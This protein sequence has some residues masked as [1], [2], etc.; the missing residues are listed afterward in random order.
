MKNDRSQKRSLRKALLV[1]GEFLLLAVTGVIAAIL[2][3]K[4]A[5]Q[6]ALLE[7]KRYQDSRAQE[8]QNKIQTFL[9]SATQL[10]ETLRILLENY[11]GNERVRIEEYLHRI[12]ESAPASLVYGA[13]A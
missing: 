3:E 6:T 7:V 1:F 4:S 5:H 9:L 2:V 8:V 11:Q 13:G 10:A 12:L